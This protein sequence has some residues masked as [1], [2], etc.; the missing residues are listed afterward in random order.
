VGKPL[1]IALDVLLWIVALF[2][3]WIFSR[4]GW[5]KFSDTSGW[6][7]AFRVWHYPDWF[8]VCVGVAEVA[9]ALLLLTRRTAAG[10]ALVIIVIMI[11]AMC[12]HVWWGQPRQVTSEI[13]PLLLAGIV[14]AGRWSQ[15]IRRRTPEASS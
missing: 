15:L 6:A 4:Q 3:V 7:K 13:F 14:A 1:R 5:A 11:G 9:A 2:L 8:R 12:T 10:G